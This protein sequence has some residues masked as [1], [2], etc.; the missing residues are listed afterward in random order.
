MNTSSVLK[1]KN[2]VVI[3]FVNIKDDYL[4]K[5]NCEFLPTSAFN[6]TPNCVDATFYFSDDECIQ[7]PLRIHHRPV[8][9][10]DKGAFFIDQKNHICRFDFSTT[11]SSGW[12]ISVAREFDIHFFYIVVLYVLSCAI[13]C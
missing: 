1:F 7:G 3:Q 10:D 9:Y 12:S 13:L 2:G 8:A 4:S 5:I 11:N 6:V